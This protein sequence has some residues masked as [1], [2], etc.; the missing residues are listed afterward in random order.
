MARIRSTETKPE[1]RLR[2]AL[3]AAGFRFRKNV[4]TLPGTPDIAF[5]KHHYV[6]QVRG[7]FW[8]A[9]GCKRANIPTTNTDYWNPKLARNTARDKRAD[10]DLAALG[11]KVRVVWEC[12]IAS[13]R[14]LTSVAGAISR[15]LRACASV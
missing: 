13:E 3:F 12:E 14:Q 2:K 4:R 15:E 10:A 6:I 7:C 9:H 8:H 1:V 5:P 11:W